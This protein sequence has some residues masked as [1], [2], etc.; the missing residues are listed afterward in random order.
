MAIKPGGL[1]AKHFGYD[2]NQNR[3]AEPAAQ[4]KVNQRIA[5]GGE[6]WSH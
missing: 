4:Q 6:H 3:A 5:S 2:E 1:F